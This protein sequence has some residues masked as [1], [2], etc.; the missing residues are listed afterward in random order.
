MSLWTAGRVVASSL[1]EGTALHYRCAVV[2][3][4]SGIFLLQGPNA[5]HAAPRR[6]VSPTNPVPLMWCYSRF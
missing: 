4:F 3:D 5:F 1:T 6:T 2:F